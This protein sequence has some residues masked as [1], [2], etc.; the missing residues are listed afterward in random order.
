MFSKN[1]TKWLALGLF[2]TVYGGSAAAV[3]LIYM[4]W[5]TPQSYLYFLCFTFLLIGVAFDVSISTVALVTKPYYPPKRSDL[6]D[7]PKVALLITL[8]DDA[9]PEVLELLDAQDYPNY[10]VYVLDDS[11]HPGALAIVNAYAARYTI[12]RR[13]S[14]SGYKA[15]NLN[16]WLDTLSAPYK[17]F[18]ILDNDSKLPNDFL[19]RALEYAEHP[20]NAGVAIFQSKIYNWNTGSRF[21]RI[22]GVLAPLRMY[23]LERTTSYFGNILSYGHNVLC[24]TEYIHAAGGFPEMITAEDT[25][26]TLIL[27]GQ[28]YSTTLVDIISYDSEPAD[29]FRYARRTVRWAKQ[30][31]EV[32]RF[33]WVN[34]SLYLKVSLC[35]NLYTY[36]RP[37]VYFVLL[38]FML[39]TSLTGGLVSSPDKAIEVIINS[40]RYFD[41]W[42]AVLVVTLGVWL[43]PLWLQFGLAARARVSI[44]SML[45]NWLLSVA[46]M[47]FVFVPM[48]VG[49]LRVWLG[50][51][52]AFTPTNA[53]SVSP[54]TLLTIAKKMWILIA[55]S[56]LLLLSVVVKSQVAVFGISAIWALL[57]LFSPAILWSVQRRQRE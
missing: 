37:L 54:V 35:Y 1:R 23:T 28:G 12:I 47:H 24:R 11:S 14:R 51:K 10:D 53:S 48:T 5:S 16:H 20:A 44:A 17:Y 7:F 22:L 27:D 56:S 50:M 42:F 18:T 15:G 49:M 4:D 39:W 9:L 40:R 55:L 41:P 6:A 2:T 26:L 25:A 19:S 8:C 29:V 46:L 30:T 32:F 31:V 52:V 36:I 3:G 13:A 57:I 43:L 45:L 33:P 38:L 21:A 34:S